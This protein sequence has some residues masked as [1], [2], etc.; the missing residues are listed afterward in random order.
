MRETT[1][2]QLIFEAVKVLL[3][4]EALTKAEIHDLTDYILDNSILELSAE[5]ISLAEGN[6][7]GIGE[8]KKDRTFILPRFVT[9][10]L[11]RPSAF[12]MLNFDKSK[13]WKLRSHNTFEELETY[14][15]YLVHV[16]PIVFID[17]SQTEYELEG[18]ESWGY[19]VKWIGCDAVYVVT[20]VSNGINER[21]L[22]NSKIQLQRRLI[23]LVEQDVKEIQAY[24]VI[25][26]NNLPFE[27]RGSLYSSDKAQDK[28]P[29]L[30]WCTNTNEETEEVF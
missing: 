13:T 12:D 1:L 14:L 20:Y 4:Q 22:I 24:N 11:T 3:K 30:I 16:K 26:G 27:V 15:T 6:Y 5:K 28:E 7:F 23:E 17:G 9:F 8:Y 2:R 29:C 25:Q 21:E 19:E 10:E 18:K